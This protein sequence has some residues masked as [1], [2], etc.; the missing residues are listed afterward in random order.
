M[1]LR[2]S[3]ALIC[4]GAQL[5]FNLGRL[6]WQLR[7]RMYPT[8]LPLPLP[9]GE[10]WRCTVRVSL[11]RLELTSVTK[12]IRG[13][14]LKPISFPPHCASIAPALFLNP[15]HIPKR[16]S[17]RSSRLLFATARAEGAIAASRTMRCW[18]L[19][20]RRPTRTLLWSSSHI[21]RLASGTRG[22]NFLLSQ[23]T[24]R[25][26]RYLQ[27]PR[28]GRRTS[29]TS[30]SIRLTN[31]CSELTHPS[32]HCFRRA[33]LSPCSG[34]L[35]RM[36]STCTLIAEPSLNWRYRAREIEWWPTAL[37]SSTACL[38]AP[39]THLTSVV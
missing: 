26:P 37:L 4:S 5:A 29:W 2:A 6:R 14:G 3:G 22:R 23:C 10:Y 39:G 21:H 9:T 32:A 30:P 12:S 13:L 20:R 28:L 17:W 15:V 1:R 8:A 38:T 31:R 24:L 34:K 36:S 33:T 18:P 7:A 11:A 19:L 16:P 35:R 27:P 25:P